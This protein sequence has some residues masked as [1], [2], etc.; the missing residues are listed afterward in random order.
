MTEDPATEQSAF[1]PHRVKPYHF[2][3][4]NEGQK[5]SVMHERQQQLKEAEMLKQ[6][7]KEED[8]LW[9]LQQEHLRKL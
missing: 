2:K 4:F 7:D 3:G 6:T 5:G 8:R 1:A 9:A